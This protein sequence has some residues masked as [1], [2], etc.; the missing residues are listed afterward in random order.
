MSTCLDIVRR[1]MRLAAG[2]T[3]VPTGRD[4]ADA[5]QR[6]QSVILG[7]PGFLHNGSWRDRFVS[8]AYTAKEFDRITVTA[9]GA[10]TLPTTITCDGDTRLPLDLAKVQI[11]GTADNAGLWLYSVSK[12]AWGL[13]SGLG[14]EDESPFGDEDDDGLAAQLAVVLADEFG[15]AITAPTIQAANASKA[16]LRSRF[17]KAVPTC[18]PQEDY[19]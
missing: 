11:L 14:L 15:G 3:G 16:S 6:L 7:L 10:V 2:E 9:P 4:A 12:G 5:M 8:D 13:A 17:K 1:A 18:C 19:A